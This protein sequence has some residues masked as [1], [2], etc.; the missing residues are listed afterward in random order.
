MNKFSQ[1]VYKTRNHCLCPSPYKSWTRAVGA[2]SGRLP[3]IDRIAGWS[4]FAR[5]ELFNC[6]YGMVRRNVAGS[7]GVYT[8][9]L[10]RRRV[11]T[12][13]YTHAHTLNCLY[14]ASESQRLVIFMNDDRPMV[15][16]KSEIK[17][18]C[19]GWRRSC[20]GDERTAPVVPL[21]VSGCITRELNAR[22]RCFI[23]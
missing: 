9:R 13:V 16:L 18:K 20:I 19:M 21:A 8:V 3:H 7:A 1:I 12:L 15:S 5:E 11:N 14:R 2:P 22:C 17:K 10:R 4:I 23:D 6:L